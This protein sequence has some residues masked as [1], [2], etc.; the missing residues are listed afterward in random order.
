MSE[1]QSRYSI[2]ERLAQRK[3]DI[4]SSKS[5]LKEILK[6]K[7]QEVKEYSDKQIRLSNDEQKLFNLL[8]E[9]DQQGLLLNEAEIK[10]HSLN[11]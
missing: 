5:E 2:V 4:M 8:K 7:E 3:L 11:F 1:S 9:A 10:K 6:Y